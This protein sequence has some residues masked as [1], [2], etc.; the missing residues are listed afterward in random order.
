MTRR[1]DD[2]SEAKLFVILW[3]VISSLTILAWW[4]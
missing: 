1:H 2:D 3:I 4:Q